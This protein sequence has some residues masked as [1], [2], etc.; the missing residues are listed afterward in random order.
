MLSKED[1]RIATEF[2][3]RLMLFLPVLEFRV[4][5]SR[6]RGEALPESDLDTFI[7]VEELT[8]EQRRRISEIAWEV[9]FDTDRVISTFVTTRDQLKIGPLAANPILQKID[10]E[11]ILL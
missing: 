4:Y 5:G 3:D 8:S 6:A 7:V 11:G 1:L 9:G 10:T 2:K